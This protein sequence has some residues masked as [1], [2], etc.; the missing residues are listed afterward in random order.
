M[1]VG[2]HYCDD[3]FFVI[4]VDIS[5]KYSSEKDSIFCMKT[6]W[7]KYKSHLLGVVVTISL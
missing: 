4:F 7:N 2:F 6:N 1:F 5:D 3:L